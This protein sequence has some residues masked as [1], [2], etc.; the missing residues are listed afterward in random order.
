MRQW[1]NYINR[2]I[3]VL[4][5]RISSQSY[6]SIIICKNSKTGIEKDSK[7]KFGEKEN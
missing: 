2:N 5:S 1:R 4:Q 7:F 3:V 6:N